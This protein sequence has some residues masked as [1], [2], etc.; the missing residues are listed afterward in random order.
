MTGYKYT[1]TLNI[2]ECAT[3]H[4]NFGMTP[5][6][7][8]ARRNDHQS[9]FCPSG[10]SNYYNAESN[11]EKLRRENQR[12]VQNRAYLEDKISSKDEKIDRLERSRN[13]HKGVVTRIKNRVQHGVC[14]CCNRHFKNL[15]QHM[16]SKHPNYKKTTEVKENEIA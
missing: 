11:E 4:M 9:F 3:C 6:F 10:H 12:L 14:P 13:A 15:E 2:V 5:E 7:E 1:G 16:H 8:Q